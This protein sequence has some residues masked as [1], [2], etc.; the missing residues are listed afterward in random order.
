MRWKQQRGSPY[1]PTP[2]AYRG[3]LYVLIDNGILS[4]YDLEAGERVYRTRLAQDASGFSASPVASDGQIYFTSEDGDV[5]IVRAGEEFELLGR[6][7][8]AEVIMATP[9]ISDRLL[10]LRGRSHLYAI[11]NN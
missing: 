6:N 2:L 3:F 7:S 4:A 8:M 11:G 1:T 9:A 5:F 10:F